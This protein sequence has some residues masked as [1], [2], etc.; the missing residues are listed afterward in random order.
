MAK[1]RIVNKIRITKRKHICKFY[2]KRLISSLS[3]Q[4]LQKIKDH[5]PVKGKEYE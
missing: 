3:K 5:N 4:F 2:N 1:N